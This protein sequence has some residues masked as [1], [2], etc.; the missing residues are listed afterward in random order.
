MSLSKPQSI[1]PQ[2][3]GSALMGAL[4][5]MN[6][7]EETTAAGLHERYLDDVFRYVLRRV[8]RVE[9]AEDITAEVFAAAVAGLPRFRSQCPPY[10]W[11]LSIARRQIARA[12][13][14]QAAR[15][16]T[17]ASELA[18]AGPEAEAL[19]EALAAIEGP[20]T[21]LMRAEARRVL[22]EL[23]AQLKPD[24]REALMLQYGEQLSVGEI[25]HVMG[26]SPGS[27]KG[28]LERAKSMLY[29]RGRAYFL[30]DDVMM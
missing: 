27:V 25:A 6:R 19:W 9:E 23:V 17:L 10:L 12:H 3:G 5:R 24:Q 29:R 21:G 20:E 1:R 15:R 18:D 8:L 28:L 26:R 4:D 16:E 11:L 14:R 22:G 2:N 30:G 7:A 13:R